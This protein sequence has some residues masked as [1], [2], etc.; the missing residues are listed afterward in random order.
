MARE[1]RRVLGSYLVSS[2]V[3]ES[4]F[5]ANITQVKLSR[6]LSQA[7]L[8][9]QIPATWNKDKEEFFPVF[10]T[11]VG[12]LRTHLSK[13]LRSKRIPYLR[14]VYDKSLDHADKI[15][16]ILMDIKRDEESRSPKT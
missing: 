14:L 7:T 11:H 16:K 10:Q 4:I 8:F 3:N 9:Y 5:G 15:N 2:Q 12:Q 13:T 6:D 1:I